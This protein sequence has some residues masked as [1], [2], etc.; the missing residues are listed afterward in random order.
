MR[1]MGVEHDGTEAALERAR[2][3]LLMLTR[4]NEAIRG[5]S[6]EERLFAEVC[7]V[8]VETGGYRM[9]WVGVAENDERKTVRPVAHAG[10]ED[11][12]LATI[13]VV[14][15]DEARGRGPSGT[16]AREGRVSVGLDF[17]SEPSLAPWREE[18]LRRGYESSTG[19]PIA[20]GGERVGVL[21]MYSGD[22]R[23]FSEE[24]LQLLQM[25]AED[26]GYGAVS[27]RRRRAKEQAEAALI[28]NQQSLRALF[29]LSPDATVVTRARDGVLLD[30]NDSFLG[31]TGWSREQVLGRSSVY[32]GLWV[33]P[34]MRDRMVTLVGMQGVVRNFQSRLRTRQ[35]VL[36]DVPVSARVL[37][38]GG[39]PALVTLV[40]DVTEVN[41]NARRY[42]LL[43]ANAQ[44]VIWILDL[45][46]QRFSYVSPAIRRLRGLTVEEAL[47]EPLEESMTPESLA[48][49]ADMLGRPSRTGEVGSAHT[50][51][52]DQPCADGSVKHVEITTSYVRNEAGRPVEVLG[53]SRDATAR[54]EA[55]QALERR[56][57]ELRTIL[58]TAIDGFLSVDATG[59]LTDVNEASCAITGYRRDELLG[60]HVALLEAS[61]SEQEIEARMAR[62][63]AFGSDRFE[64]RYRR[65]D[66]RNHRRGA[67][68]PVLR[69]QRRPVPRLPAGRDR[70]EARGGRAAGEP[71][72]ARDHRP[73]RPDR[74][75]RHPGDRPTDR[76][77]QR[78]LV[79]AGGVEPRRG[80]GADHR[81]SRRVR[82]RLDAGQAL[83]RAAPRG[84]R[85][86]CRTQLRRRSGEVLDLL[87]TAGLAGDPRARPAP[88]PPGTM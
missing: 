62:I 20:Y 37:T 61:E 48:R 21:T 76:R 8:I 10:H 16:A 47:A 57:R 31:M 78:R 66:G 11:G 18:A 54:V 53:V 55:E 27:L 24:E 88:S 74:L 80:G 69:R 19:L 67:L 26:I 71:A 30:V 84:R 70:T 34:G 17:R 68:R 44:D 65:K 58:Q 81:R 85:A 43:A 14:W 75:P 28:E 51:V 9:C 63:Q 2:R 23:V 77:R 50:G 60:A 15:A 38:Y 12:Y 46:T 64:T 25:L 3:T 36:L 73:R 22:A 40:R 6:T 41:R 35:G 7:R 59:R 86:A 32:L 4:C 13:D 29:D 33:N 52:F 45:E 42:Q 1:D 83:R 5:A 82:R 87:I 72:A 56:E 39:E 49:V 79:R